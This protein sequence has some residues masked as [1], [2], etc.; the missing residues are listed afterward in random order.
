MPY[1]TYA[2]AHTSVSRASTSSWSNAL[3][4]MHL[5]AHFESFL[6]ISCSLLVSASASVRVVPGG[7]LFPWQVTIRSFSH[8]PIL[9]VAKLPLRKQQPMSCY[10]ETVH[11]FLVLL[12]LTC[13]A[14][15]PSCTISYT[16]LFYWRTPS[17]KT[18]QVLSEIACLRLLQSWG[19][20]N[21]MANAHRKKKTYDR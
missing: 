6:M 9:T 18:L 14:S 19:S 17:H 5:I 1:T 16:H 3:L 11:K 4:L 10:D 2:Y 13:Q 12:S 20:T 21:A 8:V 7:K 15:S